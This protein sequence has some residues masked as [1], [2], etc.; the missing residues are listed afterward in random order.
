M[1]VKAYAT[2]S[3]TLLLV[4]W[5]MF[6]RECPAASAN[7]SKR[8]AAVF[9][10]DATSVTIP[11]KIINGFTL[12]EVMVNNQGPYLFMFDSGCNFF[13][14][15]NQ[16]SKELK[17][18]KTKNNKEY[19]TVDP[20]DE[21]EGFGVDAVEV[22]RLKL[23]KI[24]AV[25]Q[26][27]SIL[28]GHAHQ[29]ISGIFGIQFFKGWVLRFD[30]PHSRLTV[31]RQSHDRQAG[32]SMPFRL[33]EE[34]P[35]IDLPIGGR[36][37]HMLLSTAYHGALATTETLRTEWPTYAETYEYYSG[38]INYMQPAPFMMMRLKEDFRLG[39]CEFR[40]PYI[41]F[42]PNIDREMIGMEILGRITMELDLNKNVVR[43]EQGK[44]NPVTYEN[45]RRFDVTM[46][47]VRGAMQIF[48]VSDRLKDRG[49]DIQK[50]D[51]VIAIEGKSAVRMTNPELRELIEKKDSIRLRLMRNGEIFDCTVPVLVDTFTR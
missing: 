14:I 45:K 47:S 21:S 25:N 50:G 35:E 51:N 29:R 4:L 38:S 1:Q 42:S 31:S 11:L 5:G 8:P 17:L 6:Q 46:G 13:C 39:D 9:Q 2:V 30:F 44:D 48:T 34:L 20:P 33:V 40:E 18:P 7:E 10:S 23:G 37:R 16:L 15:S 41:L 27:L 19:W 36:I 12:I 32:K 26:D 49:L 28:D 43:F 22:G 3:V 24:F